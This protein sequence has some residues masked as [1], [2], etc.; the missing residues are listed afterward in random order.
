MMI[1]SATNESSNKIEEGT[2]SS[3]VESQPKHGRG[4]LVQQ[5]ARRVEAYMRFS[6]VRRDD[7]ADHGHH[8]AQP[9][10][11][12]HTSNCGTHYIKPQR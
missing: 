10:V 3:E 5:V 8:T 6:G 2:S 1:Q 9:M 4:S 7:A 11:P 12:S